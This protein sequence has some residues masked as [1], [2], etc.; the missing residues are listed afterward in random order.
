MRVRPARGRVRRPHR[1]NQ[2]GQVGRDRRILPHLRR[3]RLQTGELIQGQPVTAPALVVPLAPADAAGVVAEDAVEPLPAPAVFSVGTSH[4]PSPRWSSNP[5]EP[6]SRPARLL[7]A[8]LRHDG[9]HAV[10]AGN[11]PSGGTSAITPRTPRYNKTPTLPTRSQQSHGPEGSHRHGSASSMK[12]LSK[13][14][15]AA[16]PGP[17]RPA[18]PGPP[19]RAWRR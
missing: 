15:G 17:V 19:T 7:P 14:V 18:R 4:R 13:C 16:R 5:P 12:I 11:E 9:D 10:R 3:F 1:R 6:M 2:G 8:H